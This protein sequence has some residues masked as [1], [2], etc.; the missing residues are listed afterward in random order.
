MEAQ[1]RAIASLRGAWTF[2]VSSHAAG[3][4]PAIRATRTID[5][6]PNP[7]LQPLEAIHC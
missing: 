2:A 5:Q 7:D 1:E 3:R 6:G 4:L